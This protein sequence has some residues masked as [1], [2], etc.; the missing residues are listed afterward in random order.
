M[1]TQVLKGSVQ[2]CRGTM[3]KHEVVKDQTAYFALYSADG[4]KSLAGKDLAVTMGRFHPRSANIKTVKET[5]LDEHGDGYYVG[6]RSR[7]QVYDMAQDMDTRATEIA[8][9]L[10]HTDLDDPAGKWYIRDKVFTWHVDVKNSDGEFYRYF[11][12]TDALGDA[13]LA[14]DKF[15]GD[16]DLRDA[17]DAIVEPFEKSNTTRTKASKKPF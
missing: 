17:I 2:F 9:L 1:L 6:T 4:P 13:I 5:S 16:K 3:D 7:V 10:G 15:N 14:M 8:N 11:V 12:G